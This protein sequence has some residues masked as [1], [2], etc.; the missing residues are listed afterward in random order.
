[1]LKAYE[2]I[3]VYSAGQPHY[4]IAENMGQAERT[5]KERYGQ[6]TKIYEIKL[7]SEYVLIANNFFYTPVEDRDK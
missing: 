6:F 5:Y 4:V 3:T 7:R 2:I 1:M